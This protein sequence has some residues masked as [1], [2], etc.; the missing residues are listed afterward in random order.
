MSYCGF[1][2]K[3]PEQAAK[4]INAARVK[5]AV[6]DGGWL[7]LLLEDG[8]TLFIGAENGQSL[9]L[10]LLPAVPEFLQ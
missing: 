8:N 1:N 4:L 9:D 2:F 5:R 3:S 6:A 7:Y 10:E